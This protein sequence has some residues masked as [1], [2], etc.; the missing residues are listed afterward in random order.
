MDNYFSYAI[1]V[2]FA[3]LASIASYLYKS[4]SKQVS[5]LEEELKEVAKD[6]E[7]QMAKT[8]KATMETAIAQSASKS[9]L[10]ASKAIEKAEV[11]KVEIAEEIKDL[12]ND[13]PSEEVVEKVPE[14]SAKDEIIRKSIKRKALNSTRLSEK[15]KEIAKKIFTSDSSDDSIL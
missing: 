4:K 12:T 7:V 13:S 3:V 15:E 8:V 11:S 6:K 10:T 1:T 5:K 9:A 14:P 2:F